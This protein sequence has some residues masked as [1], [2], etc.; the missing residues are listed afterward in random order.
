MKFFKDKDF[1]EV[2]PEQKQSMVQAEQEVN[3]LQ[4]VEYHEKVPREP[5]SQVA[6]DKSLLNI[7]ARASIRKEVV[8][9]KVKMPDGSLQNSTMPLNIEGKYPDAFSDD[10]TKGCYDFD[11]QGLVFENAL[12]VAFLQFLGESRGIDFTPAAKFNQISENLVINISRGKNGFASTMT[13]TDKHVS[14][15]AIQHAFKAAEVK[16]QKKWGPF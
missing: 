7:D 16:T 15:G 8:P 3:Q 10:M 11:E 9:T 2:S 13:K 12:G 14:E 1:A 6:L 5:E 4:Y